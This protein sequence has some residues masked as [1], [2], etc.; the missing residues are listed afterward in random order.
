MIAH[1]RHFLGFHVD[2][3][4]GYLLHHVFILLSLFC[5][6]QAKMSSTS[7][8]KP[9]KSRGRL[10][11]DSSKGAG[12]PK[13]QRVKEDDTDADTTTL[14]NS[15]Y[16]NFLF[17]SDVASE[18]FS[19]LDIR[20]LYNVTMASRLGMC[21]LRHEH[22]V[23]SAMM[24][25]GH[26]KT[27][28]ERLFA[29]IEKRCIWIPSPLRML[30]LVNGRTCERCFQGRVH[31]VS[32]NFGVFYC[33]HGCIQDVST[34]GVVFNNKW[35]PFLVDKQRIAKAAYS[36]SAYIWKRPY[37]DVCGER[38]GPLVSMIEMERVMQGQGSIEALLKEKDASDPYASEKSI[39]DISRVFRDTQE[40]AFDR[41]RERKEKKHQA[42]LHA[43]N[44]RK[45]KVM[46]MI[47]ILQVELDDVPW[48]DAVLSHSWI[49]SSC[50]QVTHFDCSLTN[51][52]LREYSSAPS[53]ASKK[54]LKEVTISLRKS[55][56]I[57]ESKGFLD[58]SF[59]SDSNPAERAVKDY[60]NDE[61][62]DYA[63][64]KL[65]MNEWTMQ[66]AESENESA[67]FKIL[68]Y[69]LPVDLVSILAPVVVSRTMVIL[70][71]ESRKRAKSHKPN[72]LQITS[73]EAA[74]LLSGRT[75]NAA[76]E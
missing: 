27:N 53:K 58:L 67:M 54:K 20:S 6:V 57:L 15:T 60:C 19:F 4:C 69:S 7:N 68:L 64:L 8:G 9:Q 33:F 35:S 3:G 63:I 40:A 1:V 61:Y 75:T 30:R 70:D 50:K 37:V 2:P 51:E 55:V 47:E 49:Q 31:L 29:L 72:F 25:G 22:V 26:S 23:R 44:K 36:S 66:H 76:H 11:D 52:L 56:R 38:C 5:L 46:A 42:S 73:W 45:K 43:N 12:A 59:L 16:P 10:K 39:S 41:I 18:I 34:K 62:P 65:L 13:R 48:K 74:G 71:E 32:E 14:G 24:Q 28:M 21:L 17:N